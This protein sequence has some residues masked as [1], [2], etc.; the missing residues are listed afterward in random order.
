[1]IHAIVKPTIAN[2]SVF[3]GFFYKM[4]EDFGYGVD[5]TS[6]KAEDWWNRS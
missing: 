4:A 3:N 1:M 5:L 6:Q 2:V